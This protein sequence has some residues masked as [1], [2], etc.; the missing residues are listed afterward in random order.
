MNN[1]CCVIK[2]EADILRIIQVCGGGGVGSLACRCSESEMSGD[3]V[4]PVQ[5]KGEVMGLAPFQ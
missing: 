3:Q 1:K 5:R 4:L 2:I